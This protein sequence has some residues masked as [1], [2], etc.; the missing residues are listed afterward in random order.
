V[1]LTGRI[2]F[3]IL[4]PSPKATSPL[5]NKPYIGVG[6]GLLI[7]GPP[8]HR[9]PDDILAK[10]IE[11]LISA[12]KQ[13]EQWR[14]VASV[15]IGG[16]GYGDRGDEFPPGRY[17]K[18]GIHLL[19]TRPSAMSVA[20]FAWLPVRSAEHLTPIE[21]SGHHH[22]G[23]S[24]QLS[25]QVGPI[26]SLARQGVPLHAVSQA[27]LGMAWGRTAYGQE[28]PGGEPVAILSLWS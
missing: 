25:R 8:W 24:V 19:M 3:M 11:C 6:A 18:S 7:D 28:L 1:A 27:W 9:H 17:I 26:S 21:R 20:S 16:V 5:S 13:S 4:M 22:R 12:L 14:C 10:N 2:L 15:K 23:W